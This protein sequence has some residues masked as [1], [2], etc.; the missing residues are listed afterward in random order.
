MTPPTDP[1]LDRLGRIKQR[2]RWVWRIVGTYATIS[3]LW[4]LLS[5][6]AVEAIVGSNSDAHT[7]LSMVKGWGFVAAT[8][9]LLAFWLKR[10]AAAINA[11][12]DEVNALHQRTKENEQRWILAL[13]SS[14]QGVW[15]WDAETN[16]GF[17]SPSWSTMLGYRD[18][19][20]PSNPDGW[21]ELVHPDDLRL[22]LDAVA[23]TAWVGH[24]RCST[25]H[26]MRRADGTY[27]WVMDRSM[28]TER[29]DD[30][31][32]KR[33]LGVQIDITHQREA[34]AELD[35]HRLR[36]ADL[37]IERT[38]ELEVANRSL[39]SQMEEVA[40]LY[41]NAPC[42]YHSIGPDATVL[43]MND[44]ELRWLGYERDEV[45]GCMKMPELLTDDSRQRFADTF[46]RF[47]AGA[48]VADV[49]FEFA[50]KDGSLLPVVLSSTA[51]RDAQGNFV[52]S[53]STVFDNRERRA[54]ERHVA[55]LNAE[56][57]KRAED[58]E[59]ASRAK[60]NFLATMSH[61]MRTPLNA[62][63]GFSHV[64]E[65]EV[66]DP[67]V[68]DR[69][70]K[71]H[72]AASHLAEII[73]DVLDLSRIEAGKLKLQAVAFSPATAIDDAIS[74]VS[75][76]AAAK[77]IT[78]S[79]DIDDAVPSVV[80]GDPTRFEQAV[81]NYLSNALKFTDGSVVKVR[82]K[83]LRSNSDQVALR[84]EVVDQGPGIAPDALRRLFTRFE[85]GDASTTRRYGGTGLGLV[86]TRQLAQAMG[87]E[88]GA[89]S[90][91]G[92]GSTFWFNA[93]FGTEV[94]GDEDETD[95]PFDLN[96]DETAW[97]AHVL[98]VE[99]NDLNQEVVL[100]LLGQLGITADVASS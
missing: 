3:A 60:S 93:T 77:S 61:E 54:R 71:V 85:Q 32:P 76:Q 82:V 87:G 91:P 17:R 13:E 78:V 97:D 59:Q 43:A 65:R 55:L 95:A 74:L 2:R 88:A 63:V 52:G 8:A 10:Y 86:I 57:A 90:T 1:E 56:L 9:A 100:H 50:R 70:R 96:V 24:D 35:A 47:V 28:V 44:T 72:A 68:K 38:L 23:E 45:V 19:E 20:V 80:R 73:N 49:D 92:I 69:L 67:S 12:A 18:G 33:V 26:R 22:V 46:P 83:R 62:I 34:I 39:V 53:R 7:T 75:A 11:S 14:G 94:A 99:D 25:E 48:T 30:G 89:L 51:I 66:A 36:L 29:F 42:G 41:N 37:V 58:A 81:L 27:C 5:D 6:L 79:I 21:L 15:D 4:I 84:V 31:R 64:L 40:D 98:V 16:V